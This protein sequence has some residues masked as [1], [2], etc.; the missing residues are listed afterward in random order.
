MQN[1]A[2]SMSDDLES[3]LGRGTR[4]RGRV[5]G[6][7]ALRVEGQI[8]G[9]IALVGDLSIEEGAQ[10]QGPVEADAVS[11]GGELVGDVAARGPVVIRA[12]A[13]V[14]GNMGGTEVSLEEGA[15]FKGR[16]EAVFE[17]PPELLGR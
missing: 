6:S 13:K 8:E 10:V 7:G 1:N 11:I 16:I 14:A 9:G 2:S 15:S 17:L 5:S 12:T 4:V 3:V